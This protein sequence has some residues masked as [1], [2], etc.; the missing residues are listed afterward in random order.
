MRGEAYGGLQTQTETWLCTLSGILL[1]CAASH[2]FVSYPAPREG[3]SLLPQ[4]PSL[5]NSLVERGL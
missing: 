2:V 4:P 3:R 1:K 5:N